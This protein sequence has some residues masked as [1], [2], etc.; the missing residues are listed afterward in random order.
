MFCGI[1]KL[2]FL[3]IYLLDFLNELREF[4]RNG[5][6]YNDEILLI[7]FLVFV[8]D[9]LVRFFLKCIK[10]FNGYYGC[11][12][13]VIKGRWNNCVIFYLDRMYIL[14]MDEKF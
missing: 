6:S 14:R 8:C 1:L 12:R 10:F 13:C 9:V 4:K 3:D 5:V 2:D 11:E 7:W